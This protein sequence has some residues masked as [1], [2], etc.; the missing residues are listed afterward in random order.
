VESKHPAAGE[1]PSMSQPLEKRNHWEEK[2]GGGKIK[3]M[4]TQT[5][6][7]NTN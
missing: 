1:S 6:N 4:S 2:I 3:V 7:K 5:T